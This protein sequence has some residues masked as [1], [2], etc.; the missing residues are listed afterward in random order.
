MADDGQWMQRPPIASS[1]SATTLETTPSAIRKEEEEEEEVRACL[2]E[3]KTRDLEPAHN[4]P[5]LPHLP[6]FT[7]VVNKAAHQNLGS[8]AHLYSTICCTTST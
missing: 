1:S 3:R 7:V 5:I 8:T 6:K 4:I 2:P